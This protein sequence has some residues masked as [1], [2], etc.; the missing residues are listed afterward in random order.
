MHFPNNFINFHSYL[1]VF[2]SN[3][4]DYDFGLSGE[5][6]MINWSFIAVSIRGCF[7]EVGD[8][9]DRRFSV[10]SPRI[11]IIFCGFN[12]GSQRFSRF[13]IF[14][15]ISQTVNQIL[16]GMRKQTWGLR[17]SLLGPFTRLFYKI[18]VKRK[19]GWLYAECKYLQTS[20]CI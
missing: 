4:S 19:L 2:F 11:K 3:T 14:F 15:E 10:M 16:N 18:T 12:F 1:V 8:I 20:G 17:I 13:N 6:R 5:L 9:V 7:R